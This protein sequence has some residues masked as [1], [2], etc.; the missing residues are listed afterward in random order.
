MH[1]LGTSQ[2][3]GSVDAIG[4][5]RPDLSVVVPAFNEEHR[6]PTLLGALQSQLDHATTEVVLVDDG[7]H[8][9]TSDV[10]YR[11]L[12]AMPLARVVRLEQ[13]LGKGGAVRAGVKE[14]T[15][16]IVVYMDADYATDL[17]S[18]D[19]LTAAL[20]NADVSIGSRAHD[21]SIVEH[22]RL[23]RAVMGRV[24]N[25]LTRLLAGF[26]H[27]DTQCGF[28]AFHRPV[29]KLL[30]ELSTVNGFAFDVEILQ[31]AHK[32]GLRVVEAPV[33]WQHVDGSKI[34]PWT[35]SFRMAGDTVRLSFRRPNLELPGLEISGASR[36]LFAT[37]VS[38]LDEP[39][40]VSSNAESVELL[41]TPNETIDESSVTD[42]FRRYDIAVKP[43][44]RDCRDFFGPG[45]A[46][47]LRLGLRAR[48][49][50][51]SAV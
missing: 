5:Q 27:L 39:P 6:L 50:A 13:N 22:A 44:V 15:G 48:D 17:S 14:A 21:S 29:A 51:P 24:F 38:E 49:F 28:K 7:S 3:V 45:R 34:S 18:L 43:V 1:I 31:L 32:L 16:R 8:D 40:L 42:H 23:E 47:T 37:A 20:A 33:Y 35:D 4:S 11:S 30:F 19:A 25:R 36:A 2:G 26:D 10:A 46:R 12:A 9:A 41:F